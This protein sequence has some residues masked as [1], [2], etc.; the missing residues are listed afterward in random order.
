MRKLR[1]LQAAMDRVVLD[2]YGWS[3]VPTDCEFILDYEV[4]EEESS[5]RRKKPWRYRWPD[6]VRDKVLALLLELNA[7]R[8][9][10][11]VRSGVAA[12]KKRSPLTKKGQKRKAD[13]IGQQ[14]S[15][16]ESLHG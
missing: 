8:A 1:E 5:S 14:I 15:L 2:A 16:T 11:E 9:N 12:K 4:D 3:D 10:E 7:E 13:R 6:E